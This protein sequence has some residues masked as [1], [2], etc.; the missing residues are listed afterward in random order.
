M[1]VCDSVLLE[2]RGLQRGGEGL[3]VTRRAVPPTW[4]RGTGCY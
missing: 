1:L 2:E 3:D 4:W